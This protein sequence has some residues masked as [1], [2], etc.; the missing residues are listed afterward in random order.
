MPARPLDLHRIIREAISKVSGDPRF[1]LSAAMDPDPM[2][3][4]VEEA[5]FSRVI[6]L[7]IENGRNAGP[8]L[9][10]AYSVDLRRVRIEVVGQL[11]RVPAEIRTII[12]SYGGTV[13]TVGTT[14]TVELLRS[15]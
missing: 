6:E 4:T 9:I 3:V 8:I 13:T 12:E 11:A 14:T 1:E 7:L 5:G 2:L 10:A 15:R